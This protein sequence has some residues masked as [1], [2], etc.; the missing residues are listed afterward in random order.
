MNSLPKL[1]DTNYE[2]WADSIKLFLAISNVDV[3]LTENEPEVPTLESSAAVTTKHEKWVHS[4]KVCLMTMKFTMDKTIKDNVPETNSA[5]EFLESVGKKFK[6]FDKTEKASYLS[7]LTKTRYD[8]V[9]GVREHAMKLT[10]WYN[11]L[12]SMKVELGSDFLVWQIL[13]SLPSEFDIL[14][15]SYNAQK[16]EWTIDEL[17]AILNQEEQNMRKGSKNEFLDIFHS[18]YF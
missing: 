4:N 18:R 8:G 15:T 9:S 12:K 14:K 11:K 1:N 2:D 16:E 3:A 6:K 13:D 17:V 5:K 10:N 7:L